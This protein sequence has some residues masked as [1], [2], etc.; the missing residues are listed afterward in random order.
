MFEAIKAAIEGRNRQKQ[1]YIDARGGTGKTFL[2]N[3]LLHYVRT[4]DDDAIAISV[5]FTGI[6]AQLLQGG[7]TFNSRFKFPLNQD[8]TATC[9]ISKQ[10]GLSRL[11][12][13]AK[14]NV[15][16]EAAMSHKFLLEGLDRTLQDLMDSKETFGGKVIVLA[17]DFRQLPT[18]I[19]KASRAQIVAASFKKSYLWPSFKIMRLEE[20]MRIQNNGNDPKLIEFDHWLEQLGN[21][22][23]ESVEEEDSFV[24]L[25]EQLR[26]KIDEKE[27]QKSMNDA[28]NFTFGDITTKSA[29][30]EWMEFVSSRAILATTNDFVNNINQICL[31]RLPGD[32]VIIPSADSTVDLDD[33]THY[34]VEYINSL[35]ISGMPPHRLNLKKGAVLMLLRNLNIRG[36]LC[37]GTRLLIQEIINDRLIKATIANGEG[38]GRTVLIP[39]IQT[40]PADYNQFGFEWQRL[41]FPVRLAFAMTIHKSQ[42]Q[43]LNGVAVWLQE[44]CFGH[45][46]LY[47]AA[48]RVG[49]PDNIKFFVRSKEGH[50][51]FTTRNVVYPEL[52]Q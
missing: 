29:M 9:N 42:G 3:R 17:G 40:R 8:A 44:P 5:A 33:A 23:L 49:N 14:V 37:N 11:I 39:K 43:T 26:V 48:L 6:A 10:S 32:E 22:R 51:D 27:Q 2:L 45:G 34:P 13:K 20:N 1:I 12:Q 46:Q 16:D 36:G 19:P 28:I 38:K 35:Q 31:D 52:L 4:L 18:V 25:P 47:V 30:P 7:R 21:G 15:W 24:T 41:Q 50:P